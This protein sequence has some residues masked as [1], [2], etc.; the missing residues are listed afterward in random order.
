MDPVTVTT[1]S[2]YLLPLTPRKDTDDPNEHKSSDKATNCKYFDIV[3]LTE[4][5]LIGAHDLK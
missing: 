3:I 2:C 5:G 1:I 4:V